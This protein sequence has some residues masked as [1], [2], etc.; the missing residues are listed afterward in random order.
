[1]DGTAHQLQDNEG[2]GTG[3]VI[4]HPPSSSTGILRFDAPDLGGLDPHETGEQL[5]AGAFSRT[6]PRSA[7]LVAAQQTPITFPR[8]FAFLIKNSARSRCAPTATLISLPARVSPGGLSCSHRILP[9]PLPGCRSAPAGPQIPSC[10]SLSPRPA[11]RAIRRVR[12]RRYAAAALCKGPACPTLSV[13]RR[14]ASGAGRPGTSASRCIAGLAI[15]CLQPR[16]VLSPSS[17]VANRPRFQNARQCRHRSRCPQ[18]PGS[19]AEARPVLRPR[20]AGG[21]PLR[22]RG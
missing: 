1:M 11:R 6:Q 2:R 18:P 13:P 9:E 17:V 14:T 8:G 7:T 5:L 4:F 20:R 22:L 21:L 19:P 3:F 15:Q 16:F 10:S 12:P